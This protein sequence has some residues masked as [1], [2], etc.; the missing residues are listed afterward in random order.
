MIDADGERVGATAD[1]G[2]AGAE[3]VE[4]LLRALASTVRSYRLYAGNGPM[5]DRFVT[6]LRGRVHAAWE[7]LDRIRLEIGENAMYW[8]GHKVLP[9][10]DGGGDL[11][12]LFYKDGIRSITLLPGLEAELPALLAVLGRAPQL[13]EEEDD[14]VTLLWQENLTAF[15]YESVDL[16]VD[17]TDIGAPSGT[18]PA[19]VDP[20]AVRQAAADPA[21][22]PKL[23]TDD[24]QETLYFL[25]EGE[26]RQLE[27]EVRL[28]EDRDLWQDVLNALLDRLEDGSV[29]RQVRI[30]ALLEEVLPSMLAAGAYDR[31][32]WLLG[33]L[34]RLATG[35]QPLPAP[36]LQRIREVFAQLATPEALQQLVQVMD[37]SAHTPQADSLERLL[38]FFPPQSLAP[39]TALL[40]V[41]L[42]PDTRRLLVTAAERL[43]AAN[44]DQ[45]VR[46]LAAEDPVVIRGALGWV[47][48]LGIGS[49]ANEVIRL[50]RHEAPQVRAAAAEAAAGLRAAVAGTSLVSLLDDPDRDVRMAAA[51]A[52]ASLEHAAARPALEA[53]IQG[54]R[55]RAADRTEKLAYFE[56]LGRV[57]GAEAVPFLDRL[58]NSRGWLGRAE[59]AEVRA[60]AAFGLAR[61]RHAAAR[62]ALERAAS[63]GDPVVRNA[64]NRSLRGGDAA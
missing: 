2:P 57:G 22:S 25:D 20:G 3:Q 47:G 51:R 14:L 53:A 10:G 52:L 38:A 19:R 40:D 54:K 4:E 46:L 58:L 21:E 36:V 32:A 8:E 31:A 15:H 37:E 41:V 7:A 42:R 60:C 43:A 27:R 62:E 55:L 11:P 61:V 23:A 1:D 9:T 56:A 12:F 45:V 49:A 48:A 18:P 26:L 50:L 64:V 29:E 34:S 16:P 13:H 6:S 59:S 35:D 5:L 63:D 33:E 24:F 44:R 28:E 30:T 39:L 17:A